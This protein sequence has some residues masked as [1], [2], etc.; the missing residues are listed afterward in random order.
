MPNNTK[1]WWFLFVEVFLATFGVI[2]ADSGLHDIRKLIYEGELGADNIINSNIYDKTIR[3]HFL[4]D[5]AILQYVIPASTFTDNVL[6]VMKT[7]ILDCSKNHLGIGSKDIQ[8]AERFRSKIKNVL[9]PLDNAR[10][11]PSLWRMVFASLHD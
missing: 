7:I 8:I 4:I 1:T 10:T 5:A 9:A 6:S 11:T 3:V 2:F